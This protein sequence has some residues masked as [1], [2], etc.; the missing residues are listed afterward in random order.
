MREYT[1]KGNSLLLE[2]K[3]LSFKSRLHVKELPHLKKQTEVHA[4]KYN[5]IYG[6]EARTFIRINMVCLV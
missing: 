5:I 3:I 1:F 4:I 2:E 6:K